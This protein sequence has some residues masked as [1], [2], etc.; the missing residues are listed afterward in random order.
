MGTSTR[1]AELRAIGFTVFEDILNDDELARAR[2]ILDRLYDSFDP[3][4]DKPMIDTSSGAAGAELM[5]RST[6]FNWAS[7]LVGK[8]AWFR[9]LMRRS[10]IFDVVAAVLGADCSLS[11]M[12]SLEPLRGHGRQTLH[13]DEG[14]VGPEGPVVVNSLWAIDD[15][16]PN[17]GAT[18]F[19]PGTH[20]T[21]ELAG[22][23][24]PRVI[25]ITARAGS[26]VVFDAHV[27]H[28]AS[29]NISGD[30]RRAVHVY[31]TRAGRRRQTDWVK[32]LDS[33]VI[34]ELDAEQRRMVG[35]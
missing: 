18:R 13:R 23:D 34:A 35:V 6:E 16:S 21:V 22:D 14:P 19:V 26:V 10:P 5:C 1:L 33:A 29:K 30:R 20:K 31:Y 2:I 3:Y 4:V 27:L 11:S 9:G 8:D 15:I 28:A 12:N 17:N 25:Q 7:V 32:Y 24:D